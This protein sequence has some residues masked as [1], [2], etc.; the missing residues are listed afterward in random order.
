MNTRD[1]LLDAWAEIDRRF[2]DK[3]RTKALA[4]SIK[5]A[6]MLDLTFEADPDDR[7]LVPLMTIFRPE[8]DRSE[9]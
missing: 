5:V 6:A 4:I 3:R 2:P 7:S 9:A 1:Q 8:P